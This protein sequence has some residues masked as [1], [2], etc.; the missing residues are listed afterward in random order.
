MYSERCPE[1][2]IELISR[3]GGASWVCPLCEQVPRPEQYVWPEV[4]RVPDTTK[5]RD[6]ATHVSQLLIEVVEDL[7]QY[8]EMLLPMYE[9]YQELAEV[10]DVPAGDNNQKEWSETIPS[11]RS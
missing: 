8:R 1:C 10:W 5:M 3:D 9:T 2:D 11:R 4:H 6:L 7:P